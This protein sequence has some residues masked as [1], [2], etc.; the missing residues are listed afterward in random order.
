[1]RLIPSSFSLWSEVRKTITRR[2][3]PILSSLFSVYYTILSLPRHYILL[4]LLACL[5]PIACS[6]LPAPCS[7]PY[8]SSNSA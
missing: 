5:L 4:L 8:N 6:L 1:L 3:L 2:P 7:L